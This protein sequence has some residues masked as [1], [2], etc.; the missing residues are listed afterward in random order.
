M[1]FRKPLFSGRQWVALM[2]VF[3][4]VGGKSI[5]HSGVH[6][7]VLDA[8][9]DVKEPTHVSISMQYGDELRLLCTGATATIP[10][11][12]KVKC[13]NDF[14]AICTPGKVESEYQGMFPLAGKEF[15]F[16]T[17]GNAITTPA[18]FRLPPLE[19]GN[20]Y[21]ERF[22]IGCVDEKNQVS[23]IDVT[24]LASDYNLRDDFSEAMRRQRQT[25]KDRVQESGVGALASFPVAVVF[26]ILSFVSVSQTL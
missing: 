24:V 11:N 16:W 20:R 14:G 5:L 7:R 23:V 1:A 21:K 9:I 3:A 2:C 12:F 4:A 18:T 22:S 19:K 8:L 17:G 15:L 6:G 10:Q 26:L 13:C 25:E